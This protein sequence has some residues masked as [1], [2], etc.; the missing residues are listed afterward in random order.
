MKKLSLIIGYALL[1]IVCTDV[2]MYG[3]TA[4]FRFST[5]NQKRMRFLVK[6]NAQI[7][8]IKEWEKIVKRQNKLGLVGFIVCFMIWGISFYVTFLYTVVWKNQNTAFIICFSVSFVLDIFLFE[9]IIELIN[10]ICY[11]KRKTIAC[12]RVIGFYLNRLR[13]FRC[14]VP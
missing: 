2:I 13:D 1:S 9:L 3:I 11:Y 10:A 12:L 5:Y 7:N 6:K 8:I 14:L 4:F